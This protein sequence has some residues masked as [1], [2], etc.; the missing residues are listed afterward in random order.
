MAASPQHFAPARAIEIHFVLRTNLLLLKW[1]PSCCLAQEK[2]QKGRINQLGKRNERTSIDS[3]VAHS[4]AALH[5]IALPEM[6]APSI[7]PSYYFHQKLRKEFSQFF[8][9]VN[10]NL[11]FLSRLIGVCAVQRRRCVHI[12][13]ELYWYEKVIIY[14]SWNRRTVQVLLQTCSNA[15]VFE[16]VAL[17]CCQVSSSSCKDVEIISSVIS[18]KE[19]GST[20][21]ERNHCWHRSAELKSLGRD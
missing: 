21:L 6:D 15:Y 10:E 11:F 13:I 16:Q 17:I 5:V 12:R 4:R 1:G 7:P 18:L 9:Q 14:Y 8:L 2:K 20:P 19:S 3:Q